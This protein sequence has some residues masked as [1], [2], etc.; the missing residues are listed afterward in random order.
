[1]LKILFYSLIL[2]VFF[3]DFFSISLGVL[4]K[5]VTL[6]PDVLAVA[7]LANLIVR[8][9]VR[10]S[11]C[12]NAK[13]ILLFAVLFVEIVAGIILNNVD[14]GTVFA[15]I[16]N[17]FKYVPLFLL[18]AIAIISET[19]FKQ[20]LKFLL[21]LA[22]LQLPVVIVQ[23]VVFGSKYTDYVAGTLVITGTLTMFLISCISIAVG[24]YFKQ[25]ISLPR[26][27]FL[28][29]ILFLPTA[30][31]ETK[32]ALVF[33]PVAII[34]VVIFSGVWRQN[35]RKIA[36]LVGGVLLLFSSYSLIYSQFQAEYNR[37][38]RAEGFWEFFT[39]TDPK[40]GMRSYI[41][42]GEARKDHPIRLLDEKSSPVTGN[43]APSINVEKVRRL[44]GLILS[45]E[46]LS[47]D[48]S[49]LLLGVGMGNA[50]V[51]FIKE[52][53]GEYAYL[54]EW[55]VAV[56][57]LT[58]ILWELG[59]L[60]LIIFL[61]FFSFII[62]D[63]VQ[64]SRKNNVFG[65]FATGWIGVV[66]IFIASMPYTNFLIFNVLGFLF[67]YFSGVIASKKVEYSTI[68]RN[69]N[70]TNLKRKAFHDFK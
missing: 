15:A 2:S 5:V 68:S 21:A 42:S 13:Y 24:F 43:R 36:I 35:K 56:R 62:Y 30:L 40:K 60:G 11:L 61:I 4:P 6:L 69:E 26:L 19:E 38:G 48:F 59:L 64:L 50:S 9:A 3:V 25:A 66:A 63:S 54:A 55:N 65:Y 31:G 18:P 27:M 67:W 46:A 8:G 32:A 1:M 39:T 22:F 20:Q 16:R 44:D 33:V 34:A 23:Y 41:Y 7:I 45:V 49:K 28:A 51:S 14:L 57:A 17:Y 29:L 47:Q 10:K 12:I 53:S 52:F 58:V 70:L 37:L